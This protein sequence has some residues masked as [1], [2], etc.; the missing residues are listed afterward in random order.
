MQVM[1]LR[2]IIPPIAC[3]LSCCAF[4][5]SN[6]WAAENLPNSETQLQLTPKFCITSS[7]KDSCQL[8]ITLTWQLPKPSLICIESSS[9]D[10]PRWCSTDLTNNSLKVAVTTNKNVDFTLLS[11]TNNQ[12]LANAILKVTSVTEPQVRRRYRNPWSLF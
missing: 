9:P 6:V 2:R 7:T 3:I 10:I 8:E 11:K 4:F 5:I 12:P 1:L